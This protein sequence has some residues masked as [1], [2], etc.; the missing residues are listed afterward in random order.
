MRLARSKTT[1]WREVTVYHS[2]LSFL[3]IGGWVFEYRDFELAVLNIFSDSRIPVESLQ[4]AAQRG[5]IADRRRAQTG[6]H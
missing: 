6:A 2:L 1:V 5:C 3:K 4:R